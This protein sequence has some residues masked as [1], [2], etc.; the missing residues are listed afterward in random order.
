MSLRI[1]LV[2]YQQDFQHSSVMRG[3]LQNTAGE[4]KDF[5]VADDLIS[6]GGAEPRERFN[7]DSVFLL[8]FPM[9]TVTRDGQRYTNSTLMFIS[10]RNRAT[11]VYAWLF[12]PEGFARK[13]DYID[14]LD[15]KVWYQEGEWLHPWVQ[16]WN[17]SVPLLDSVLASYHIAWRSPGGFTP[18]KNTRKLWEIGSA[19]SRESQKAPWESDSAR[20]SMDGIWFQSDD[21]QC[22]VLVSDRPHYLFY[23]NESLPPKDFAGFYHTQNLAAQNAVLY[24]LTVRLRGQANLCFEDYVTTI[25]RQEARR[26][27]NADLIFLLD[28]P[29]TPL[30][31]DGESYTACTL[32]FIAREDRAVI[33]LAWFFTE[34][35]KARKEYYFGKWDGV[36]RYKCGKWTHRWLQPIP[37]LAEWQKKNKK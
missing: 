15:K 8:D 27:F 7:A 30:Q 19:W 34:R 23:A 36:F 20:I 32:M 29:I 37:G 2:I 33:W 28:Y 21:K 4:P 3:Y 5:P 17:R 13:S 9:D 14:Q 1:P 11:L 26:R 31:K 22:E 12:T 35:G 25:P 10:R 6:I 16:N 18:L 24:C